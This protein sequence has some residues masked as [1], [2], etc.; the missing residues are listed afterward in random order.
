MHRYANGRLTSCSDRGVHIFIFR[1][2]FIP[3]SHPTSHFDV[4]TPESFLYVSGRRYSM[5]LRQQSAMEYLMTYGWSIVAI[6]VVVGALYSLGVFGGGANGAT[7]CGVVAG[8]PARS[9]SSTLRCPDCRR[10]EHRH[11]QD[12]DSR[13]GARR[14]A[15]PRL[16]GRAPT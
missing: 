5:T 14:T 15:P 7:G 3:V 4:A 13:R 16:Y 1:T 2:A 9:R 11:H 12:R 6:A 10:R 8:S